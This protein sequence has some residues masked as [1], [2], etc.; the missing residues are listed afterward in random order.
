[1]RA[2]ALALA[3]VALPAAAQPTVVG[4]IKALRQSVGELRG[5][6]ADLTTRLAAAEAK[7]TKHEQDVSNLAFGH[8]VLVQFLLIRGCDFNRTS[9]AGN[10]VSALVGLK[11]IALPPDMPCPPEGTRFYWPYFHG[12]SAPV[13]PQQ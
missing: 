10:W 9:T 3:L 6:V 2:L 4:E 1:M 12:G 7:V 5:Q 8:N 13:V 11:P